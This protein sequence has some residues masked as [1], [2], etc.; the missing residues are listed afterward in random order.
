MNQKK[1]QKVFKPATDKLAP[2]YNSKKK[3]KI[4]KGGR[5]SAKSWGFAE[6]LVFY[7]IKYKVRILCCREIQ[8]SIKASSKKVIEDTIDRYGVRDAFYITETGITN[9]QTGS[10]FIFEGLKNSTS[11]KSM[12]GIN[13]CWVEEAENVSEKSWTD[14][15]PT[16]R[17][18]G[19]EIWV[20]FNPRFIDDPT[21]K[22]LI[23]KPPTESVLM[24]INYMDNPFFP[25]SLEQE[26]LDEYKKGLEIGDLSQYEWIWLGKPIGEEYNTLITPGL[27]KLARERT[28][29]PKD[30]G[31]IAGLDVAR[32]GDD[33]IEFVAR[34]GNEIKARHKLSRGNTDEVAEWAIDYLVKYEI[35]VLVVDAAGSAGV[36]DRI[37]SR[38]GTECKVVEYNGAFAASS[39]DYLNLRA[40]SWDQMR[41]WV[42]DGGVLPKDPVWDE[43]SRVT[44]TYKGSNKKALLSKDLMRSKGIKSPNAGDA[45]SMTFSQKAMKKGKK[46]SNKSDFLPKSWM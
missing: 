23:E 24:D 31:I 19:A 42:Q 4:A 20:T 43:L 17:A 5:G 30:E 44:Y 28:L 10:T 6:G 39:F 36:F 14:L 21:W 40:E 7:S 32:Y 9:K 11:I 13:I 18:P 12:E 35:G 45:L 41:Q 26:R 27:I 46:K 1:I 34:C 37:K 15:G 8:K 3:W 22:L 25:E 2:L 38:M 33:D 16:I 29:Y